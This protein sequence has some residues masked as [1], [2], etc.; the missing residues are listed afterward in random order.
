MTSTVREAF[1][2]KIINSLNRDCAR[3]QRGIFLKVPQPNPTGHAAFV[4]FE[5]TPD[6]ASTYLE[7]G[8]LPHTLFTIDPESTMIPLWIFAAD[9][10]IGPRSLPELALSRLPDFRNQPALCII[11]MGCDKIH[12][13]QV[14]LIPTEYLQPVQTSRRS[15]QYIL[16]DGHTMEQFTTRAEF[17]SL[18]DLEARILKDELDTPGE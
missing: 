10:S 16:L 11:D 2:T 15:L 1:E 18:A 17:E 14:A 9:G 7:R 6:Q 4:Q 5:W 8:L 13:Q 12:G 3:R